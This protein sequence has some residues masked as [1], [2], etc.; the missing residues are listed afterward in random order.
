M[1]KYTDPLRLCR[2]FGPEN[3]AAF[4]TPGRAGNFDG[5]AH[6]NKAVT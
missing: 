1:T 3:A 6:V 5:V 4:A 2:I